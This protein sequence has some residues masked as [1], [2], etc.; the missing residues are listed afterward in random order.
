MARTGDEADADALDVVIRIGE[1]VDF[2]LA[3]VAG[4]GVDLPNRQRATERA[5]DFFL[6][7]RDNDVFFGRRGRGFGLDAGDRDLTE[8]GEH[9]VA[10]SEIVTAVRQ[11]EALVDQRKVGNDVADHSV[12]EHRPVRP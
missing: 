5:K 7:A 1:R 3:A 6:Q 2:Q 12:L 8:D 10:T 11:I 4:A 9:G